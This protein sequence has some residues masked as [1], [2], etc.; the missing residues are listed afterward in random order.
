M[1]WVA[2]P[3]PLPA[4]AAMRILRDLPYG[5]DPAQR[6]D[7]YAPPRATGAP[8]IFMVHG[9][10]WSGGDKSAPGVVANKVARWVPRGFIVVSTNYRMLPAADPV[11]QARDA[12]RSLAM[13]QRRAASWGGDRGRFILM[14]HSAGAH[15]VALLAAAPSLAARTPITPPL[16]AVAIESGALDVVAVMEARRARLFDRAFGR[17]RR[18]W[19]AASPYHAL[20]S[21]GPP[22]LLVCSTRR[23]S[24]CTQAERFIARAIAV[25]RRAS[26]LRE[27]LSHADAD[28]LLG[29][30][31]AYTRGVESFLRTLDPSLAQAL[32]AP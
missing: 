20:E 19:T 13:A 31:T 30:D 1:A 32:T 9:G 25:G 27:N 7:V 29:A 10:G 18:F 15:L 23:G 8:V 4:Q 17:D 28:R 3:L 14:G 11:A 21:A 24:S 12:A 6:F 16:G 5:P 22:I 26:L 2:A